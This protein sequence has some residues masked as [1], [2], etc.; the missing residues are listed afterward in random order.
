MRERVMMYPRPGVRVKDPITLKPLAEE[1]EMKAKNQYWLR[2]IKDGDVLL[3]KPATAK[4]PAAKTA[5][6]TG[7]KPADQEKGDTQ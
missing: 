4:K 2:R 3:G 1:G 7:K 5:S 6:A